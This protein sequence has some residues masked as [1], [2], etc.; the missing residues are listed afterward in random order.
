MSSPSGG[1]SIPEA[2]PLPGAIVFYK[3][4]NIDQTELD[5]G[6]QVARELGLTGRATRGVT[7]PTEGE[8]LERRLIRY[9][10]PE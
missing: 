10:R 7:L 9:A 4:A 3:T 8:P 2:S 6:E 5:E 1:N